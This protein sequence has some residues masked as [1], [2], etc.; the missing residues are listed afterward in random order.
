MP[1]SAKPS[2]SSL[3]SHWSIDP[4]YVFLNH[5]SFGG[6]PRR[7]LAAQDSIRARLEAEP[8]RFFVE[9][10]HGLLDETRRGVA[11]FVDCD[12][13]EL[14]LI[15]N[16]TVGVATALENCGLHAGDE[17]LVNNHEYPA[18]L[19]NARRIAGRCGASV[20]SAT[21]PWPLPAGCSGEEAERLIADAILSRVTDKTRVCLISHVTSPSGLVLPLHRI[22]PPLR[23]RNIRTVV[24]GAHAPGMLDSLSLR[25]LGCDYYTANCHKWICSPKGSAFLFVRKELQENFRPLILSNNAEAPKAGRAQFLTEFDFIGTSDPSGLLAIPEAICTMEAIGASLTANEPGSA[26]ARPAPHLVTNFPGF[27]K[28]MR[29]N[30]ELVLQAR[31]LIVEAMGIPAV[32]PEELIGSIASIFIPGAIGGGL[33]SQRPSHR[34]YADPLQ[35]RLLD[36]WQI[37]VPVW[38]VPGTAQRLTRISAQASNSIEQYRYFV[39]AL[40]EELARERSTAGR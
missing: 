8:V 25:A 23:A 36:H 40:Q 19:N 27:L 34:R 35:E 13:D 24:D 26:S 21:L 6:T 31:R 38:S 33:P 5:G 15:T 29:H 9:E 22:V 11:A 28:L 7:V 18:C 39:T 32:A 1:L 30:R 20:V 14:A 16:A 3:A 10:L 2:P 17:V 4:G 12:W 37:Q